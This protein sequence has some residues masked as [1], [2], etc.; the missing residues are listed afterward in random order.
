M[1]VNIKSQIRN[2]KITKEIIII[3][4]QYRKMHN[5]IKVSNKNKVKMTKI[6]DKEKMLIYT[7]DK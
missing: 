1:D 4:K 2:R 6:L 7:L 3:R 5:E